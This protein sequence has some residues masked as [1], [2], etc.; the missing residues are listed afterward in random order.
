LADKYGGEIVGYYKNAICIIINKE[1]MIGKEYEKMFN[2]V[3]EK[4][5]VIK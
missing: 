5:E 2:E 3:I 4:V 1:T